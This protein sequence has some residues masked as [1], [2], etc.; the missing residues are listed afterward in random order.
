[1][2]VQYGYSCRPLLKGHI[3][4]G[5]FEALWVW[6]ALSYDASTNVDSS[7]PRWY[8]ETLKRIIEQQDEGHRL[9]ATYRR[10][11][12][13]VLRHSSKRSLQEKAFLRNRIK[14]AP[15]E[16]FRPE[17]LRLDLQK[18]AARW[19][20]SVDEVLAKSRKSAEQAVHFPQ[21]LQP[22]EYLIQDLQY[23][24]GAVEFD[25]LSEPPETGAS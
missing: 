10:Q 4:V 19:G 18:I 16:D 2:P 9:I 11:L 14:Y 23:K 17:I 25:I 15:L 20:C 1:M 22:N 5:C 7:N 24:L 6:F 13:E 3:D 12:K 21:T 8:Y